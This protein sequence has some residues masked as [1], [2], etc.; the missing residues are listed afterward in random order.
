M[1]LNPKYLTYQTKGEHYIISTSGTKYSGIIK[2]NETAAFI[3]E[4][5]KTD[6]TENEIVDRLLAEYKN[7]D[8]PT[9][10][11]DVANVLDKLRYIEALE[12]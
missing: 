3:I 10:E 7:A 12:E 5:L 4:C 1:K 6:T 11:R 9:V 2:N 8:R